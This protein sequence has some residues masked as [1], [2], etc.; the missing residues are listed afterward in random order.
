MS[1]TSFQLLARLPYQGRVGIFGGSFNPAHEGHGLIADTAML[2][3]RLDRLWWLVSPQNPFKTSADMAPAA[4]RYA[5]AERVARQCRQYRRMAVL[6]LEEKLGVSHS[7]DT[8]HRIHL[9]RPRLKLYWIMGADNLVHF[10]RWQRVEILTACAATIVINRPGFRAAALA[11]PMARRLKRRSARSL[12]RKPEPH[13]WSF[14][15]S[16]L[17]HSSATDIREKQG[18][19]GTRPESSPEMRPKVHLETNRAIS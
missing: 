19:F 4:M 16:R 10:H 18:S 9:S 7:A 8:L 2:A 17:S 15:Q 14:I 3:L 13:G 11:S 12:T 1:L 5:S 6:R